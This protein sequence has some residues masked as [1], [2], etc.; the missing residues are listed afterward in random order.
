MW[1]FDSIYGKAQTYF[2]RGAEH[3]R[4]DDDEFVIWHLLG[5]EFLL[6]APLARLHPSLLAAP[7]GDSVLAANGVITSNEP[8]SVPSH[9]VLARL[10][11][12]VPDFTKE[13]HHDS[14][15]L[16]NLRNVELHTGE[17]AV[18]N[19]S[20]ELWLPK[21][22]RVADVICAHLLVELND[23][24]GADVVELGR[25]LVDLEDKKLAHEVAARIEGAR[26][27]L[28]KLTALEVES[29]TPAAPTIPVW[30]RRQFEPTV[31]CPACGT[32]G[33]IEVEQV[34]AT[35]ERLVDDLL[36]RD[37]IYVAS[38]FECPVCSL[39]LASTAEIVAA[40]LPQQFTETESEDLSERF[41]QDVMD[42][43]YGND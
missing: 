1:D 28:S 23:V 4:S 14:T 40:G 16:L 3:D 36:V 20:N 10:M 22:L 12:I 34:R 11:H 13:R 19:I 35:G 42:Y 24:L 17:A 33:T 7:E 9:T 39:G 26:A 31:T 25:S 5:F 8:K 37:V 21:L 18:G 43:D 27:F 2:A 32:V 30:A 38:S 41:Q 29:R 6:R 15:V